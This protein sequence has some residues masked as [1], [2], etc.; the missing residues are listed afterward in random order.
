MVS[1]SLATMQEKEYVGIGDD[2]AEDKAH[3]AG[4][5]HEHDEDDEFSCGLLRLVWVLGKVWRANILFCG[6]CVARPNQKGPH[7]QVALVGRRR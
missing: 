1:V 5:D 3:C 4:S 7:E 6:P 2:Q